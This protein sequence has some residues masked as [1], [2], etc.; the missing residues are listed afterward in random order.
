MDAKEQ[1]IVGADVVNDPNDKGQLNA[2]IDHAEEVSG[3]RCEQ[4]LADAG[5]SSGEQIRQAQQSNVIMPLPRASQ[6]KEDKP[7]HTSCFEYDSQS[8]EVI[9]PQQRRIPF[10]RERT[11][12]GSPVRVYRSAQTCTGCPVRQE[13][14]QDRHGRSIE[15]APWYEAV[16][17]HRKK[18]STEEAAQAYSLRAQTV[19]PV[20]AWIKN[21][22]GLRR[23]SFRGLDK[24]KTQWSMLCT[25]RNLRAIFRKWLENRQNPS[26]IG[27]NGVPNPSH[28][29]IQ[30]LFCRLFARKGTHLSPFATALA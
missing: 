3:Q 2:M 20:F 6:N 8:D 1:I 30:T 5:Y 21:N 14:T 28:D 23:W 4:T 12:S 22:D 7:Y 26:P 9:C 18:M 16:N 10:Q 15:I 11:R 17:A 13:C 29:W 19:E 24:V 27:S 25:S